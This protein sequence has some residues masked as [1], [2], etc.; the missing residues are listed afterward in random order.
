MHKLFA[1]WLHDVG[2]DVRTLPL[3]SGWEGLG[4]YC[5]ALNRES[6][7]SLLRL[8]SR[9]EGQE[10]LIPVGFREALKEKDP[11]FKMRDNVFVVAELARAASRMLFDV[12]PVSP[13]LGR[14]AA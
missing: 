14:A 8:A 1:D 6:L 4:T 2:L 7:I 12:E 10:A 11:A 3:S 5:S 9:D 13:D